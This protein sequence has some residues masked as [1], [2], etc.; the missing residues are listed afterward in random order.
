VLLLLG[1]H[2]VQHPLLHLGLPSNNTKS[3]SA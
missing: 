1:H 2:N 3:H